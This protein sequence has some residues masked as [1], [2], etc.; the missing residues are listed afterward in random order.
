MLLFL[1]STSQFF[2]SGCRSGHFRIHVCLSPCFISFSQ[3]Y[4][5]QIVLLHCYYAPLHISSLLTL[6]LWF[7][8]NLSSRYGTRLLKNESFF[9][10]II[11]TALANEH[12]VK[13]CFSSSGDD[14]DLFS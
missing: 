6:V 10:I 9:G 1:L 11:F 4:M 12:T 13:P 14:G 5:D 3:L 2:T 7:T 8:E